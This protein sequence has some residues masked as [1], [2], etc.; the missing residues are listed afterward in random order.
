MDFEDIF[1]SMEETI[2]VGDFNLCAMSEKEHTIMRYMKRL[3]FK[4]LVKKPTHIEGRIIDL[5]FSYNP[6]ENG[7]TN[8]DVKFQSPYFTD[9]D[10]VY[11]HE[12]S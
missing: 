12:V 1:D 10:I 8:I 5:V 4:Q 6:D 3:G 9:H 7:E 2:V 11:V